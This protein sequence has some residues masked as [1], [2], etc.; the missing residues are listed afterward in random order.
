MTKKQKNILMWV[1]IIILIIITTPWFGTLYERIIGRELS[2][3]FWGPS[4]PEYIDGFFM[5]SFLF[6]T[7][8]FSL[9]KKGYRQLLI[10]LGIFVLLD[11]VLG[12]WWQGLLIDLGLALVAWVL[13]QAILLISKA[14]K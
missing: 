12:G 9:F 4:N 6:L 13:A 5:S 3:G 1:G 7:L 14:V 10:I 2:P 11:V 8:L